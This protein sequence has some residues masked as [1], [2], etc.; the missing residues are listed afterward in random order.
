MIERNR[1]QQVVLLPQHRLNGYL[2][3]GVCVVD[4][5]TPWDYWIPMSRMFENCLSLTAVQ[6]PINITSV[7]NMENV[8]RGL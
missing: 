4:G 5:W 3:W 2:P 7:T 8:F 1:W 6:L